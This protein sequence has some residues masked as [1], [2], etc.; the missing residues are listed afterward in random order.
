MKE[1]PSVEDDK[2]KEGEVVEPPTQIDLLKDVE[3]IAKVTAQNE[4][5]EPEKPP[6]KELETDL[7]TVPQEMPVQMQGK[8]KEIKAAKSPQ[9]ETTIKKELL[10]EQPQ[11][12]A[13]SIKEER[14]DTWDY[15]KN[16][17]VVKQ[18]Q[19]GGEAQPVEGGPTTTGVRVKAERRERCHHHNHSFT[20]TPP[21]PPPVPVNKPASMAKRDASRT[22]LSHRATFLQFESTSE[23]LDNNDINV[24][25]VLNYQLP[26][27][28]LSLWEQ[29][30]FHICAD[31]GANRLYDYLPELLP[32]DD[33]TAVR[34]RYKP[35]VIKG[36]L[37]SIRVEVKAFYEG[38]GTVVIDE[39]HDQDTT[40]L[41]KCISYVLNDRA[42]SAEKPNLNILVVGALGGRLDH[43]F[44]N[45]NVLFSFPKT[46]I[47][48]LSDESMAFLL[49]KEF[50]HKIHINPSIE[51]PH[52]GLI[53][54]GMPST[55]TTTTGLKWNLDE[56]SME[57][58]GLISVCNQLEGEIVS[59]FSDMDLLWTVT[60]EKLKE[61]LKKN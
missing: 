23:C 7:A 54:L 32:S 18:R 11:Q 29:A 40:D 48:L 1:L 59:V 36:D 4:L 28:I 45:L 55:S 33:P 47:I 2:E 26:L 58:G 6:D 38:I 35:D 61:H 16:G 37:D 31:G 19:P 9:K 49:S 57:F 51:G 17:S 14:A 3:M 24:L 13:A 21:P 43:E 53:P 10:I 5:G 15:E 8:Q 60:I 41:H 56:T 27:I 34:T 52:C 25:V 50:T 30:C 46:R 39:S 20:T 42:L 12:A 22:E 44:G